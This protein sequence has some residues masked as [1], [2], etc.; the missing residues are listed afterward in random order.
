MPKDPDPVARLCEEWVKEQ[1]HRKTRGIPVWALQTG[2]L[3]ALAIVFVVF[4]CLM[5]FYRPG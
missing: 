1:H 2:L 5:L 4:L 3:V